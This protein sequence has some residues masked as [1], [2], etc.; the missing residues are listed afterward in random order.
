MYYDIILSKLGGFMRKYINTD[1]GF[2]EIED[3]GIV[4]FLDLNNT[5]RVYRYMGIIYD[6]EYAA[7]YALASEAEHIDLA[8]EIKREFGNDYSVCIGAKGKVVD[9]NRHYC[10]DDVPVDVIKDIL[11][12]IRYYYEVYKKD[13]VIRMNNFDYI[14]DS[15]RSCEDINEIM[16]ALDSI[17]NVR[18]RN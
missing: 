15:E 8:E 18:T 13:V 4:E 17:K 16:N 12:D 10:E 11:E 3:Y 5:G 6:G 1:E 7:N 9:F 14:D 2:K